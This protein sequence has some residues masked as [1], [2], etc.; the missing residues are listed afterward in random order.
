MDPIITRGGWGRT[1]GLLPP[2]T[3]SLQPTFYF[4]YIY[5]C[6]LFYLQYIIFYV[7]V[8]K[9]LVRILKKVKGY[10]LGIIVKPKNCVICGRIVPLINGSL[11]TQPARICRGKVTKSGR[12]IAS[13]CQKKYRNEWH[14]NK[15]ICAEFRATRKIDESAEF[16]N[17]CLK[18]DNRFEAESKFNRVCPECTIGN[19]SCGGREVHISAT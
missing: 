13:D 16:I 18:C 2:P 15:Y 8:R 19:R 14:K 10:G 3:S 5:L 12:H 1:L 7:T 6:S 17:K 9:Y 4:F 11:R